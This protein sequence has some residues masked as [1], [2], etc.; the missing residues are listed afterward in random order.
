VNAGH[1]PPFLVDASGV[2]KLASTGKPV[3]ILPDSPFQ[4]VTVRL[5]HGSS[6][7]LYTDGLNE[8]ADP[9]DEEFGMERLEELVRKTLGHHDVSGMPGRI[10]DDIIRFERGSH[11]SDDKT[12]VILR[13][14]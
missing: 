14:T 6:L 2:R 8:A 9:D 1:N 11:P 13:R 3:G 5:E 12:I 7:V 10:L 4:E